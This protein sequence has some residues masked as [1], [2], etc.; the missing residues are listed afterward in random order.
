MKISIDYAIKKGVACYEEKYLDFY[1]RGHHYI[2]GR[3]ASRSFQDS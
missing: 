2:G 3:Y 1:G